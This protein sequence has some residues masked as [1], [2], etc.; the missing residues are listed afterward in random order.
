MN[1]DKIFVMV[2]ETIKNVVPKF[3]DVDINVTDSLK[4]IG[5]NSIERMEVT[6]LLMEELEI[7]IPRIELLGP[8]NIQELIELLEKKKAL[9]GSTA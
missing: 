9:M 2:K 3:E 6:I 7:D 8:K 5:L 4:E 1:K